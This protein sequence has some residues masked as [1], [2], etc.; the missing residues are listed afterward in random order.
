MLNTRWRSVLLALALGYAFFSIFLGGYPLRGILPSYLFSGKLAV[1]VLVLS[2][3]MYHGMLNSITRAHVIEGLILLAILALGGALRLRGIAESA[4]WMPTQDEPLIVQPV[5]NILHTGNLDPVTYEY[6]GVWFY[7]LLAIYVVTVIRLVA[8]FVYKD[9]TVIPDPVFYLAGRYAT[10]LLG[11]LTIAAT[12][13]AA[14]RYFGKLAAAVAGL[15]LALSSLSFMT[16]H[17]IRLD[18]ALALFVLAAHYFFLRMLD[19][20]SSLHYFLAGVFCGL[21]VGTK[22]TV[23][24]IFASLLLAHVFAQNGKRLLNWNLL[25]AAGSAVGVFL[26]FNIFSFAHLNQFVDRLPRAVYH[27]LTPLHWSAT[28]NRP[29]EYFKNLATIGLGAVALIP[30]LYTLVRA[31]LSRDHRLLVLWCFPLLLLVLLGR[32]QSGFPRYLMPALPVLAILAGAG[33]QQLLDR[34]A[35]RFPFAHTRTAAVIVVALIAALP[36][37]SAAQYWIESGRVLRPE[38]ITEW[39]RQNIPPGSVIVMDPTGPVLPAE[40][41]SLKLV[42]SGDF[43][44]PRKFRDAEYILVSEDLFKLIPD[45][46]RI[47]MEF[48]SQTQSLDRTFRVYAPQP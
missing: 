36:A 8:T 10:A 35:V 2:A 28:D 25:L 15:T 7:M 32:Y 45:S 21:S 24:P 42:P 13:F 29:L 37:W 22:Y 44:N 20:P 33:T 27:N 1:G 14:R 5:L 23:V 38:V 19:E 18:I 46:F 48:P 34:A 39:V 12:Y 41:Y 6:G 16:A 9:P 4:L 3:L 31:V 26:L 30:A 17:Q 47:L 43:R 40:P 11:V